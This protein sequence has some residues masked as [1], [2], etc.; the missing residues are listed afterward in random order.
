MSVRRAAVLCALFLLNGCFALASRSR[1]PAGEQPATMDS[2]YF[3]AAFPQGEV[4]PRDWERFVAEVVTPR[5]PK[6]LTSWPAAGQW[7][8][9]GGA[10]QKE[11]SYVLNIVR[12]DPADDDA[13]IRDVIAV[14][15]ERFHQEAV[16]HVRSAACISF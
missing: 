14:Y 11:S 8:S 7:R 15:K 12:P 3:G 5:F 9:A 1:C 16:L 2:L 13:A 4:T 10:V 6:G